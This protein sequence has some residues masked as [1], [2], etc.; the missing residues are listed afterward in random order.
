MVFF[1]LNKEQNAKNL[2]KIGYVYAEKPIKWTCKIVNKLVT[3]NKLVSTLAE[4]SVRFMVIFL[5]RIGSWYFN[6]W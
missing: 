5:L 4:W 2:K 3:K 6:Q 1:H